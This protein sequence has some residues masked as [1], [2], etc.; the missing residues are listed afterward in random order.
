[1]TRDRPADP[2]LHDLVRQS[3]RRTLEGSA[4]YQAASPDER[5][6]L[7]QKLVNVGM[8]AAQLLDVDHRLTAEAA[9]RRASPRPPLVRAQSAGAQLGMEATR[10]AAGTLTAVRDSIN[11]PVFVQTLITGVFQAILSSSVQQ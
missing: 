4:L 3:V 7:A 6:D 5:R 10:A 8:I 9:R 11:F 1:M 2:G